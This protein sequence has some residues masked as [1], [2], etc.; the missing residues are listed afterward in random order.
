[1]TDFVAP[2]FICWGKMKIAAVICTETR[3]IITRKFVP[4][5]DIMGTKSAF[6]LSLHICD[7]EL[8]HYSL[9]VTIIWCQ[10]IRD[11]VV[12]C[13]E[14]KWNNDILVYPCADIMGLMIFSLFLALIWLGIMTLWLYLA[15]IWW[16]K[17]TLLYS[18][19]RYDEE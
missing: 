10:L 15:L 5:S 9:C 17:I 16:G 12:R 8:W 19:H 1:M 11:F 18:L 6:F 7:E 2:C 13:T 3:G 4:Y 14:I